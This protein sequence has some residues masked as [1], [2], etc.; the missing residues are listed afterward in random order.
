MP[1]S[2]LLPLGSRWARGGQ[3]SGP[4]P[5]VLR[6][7][8]EWHMM[9]PVPHLE[10]VWHPH[11]SHLLR[12]IDSL[13]ASGSCILL[14]MACPLA[15]TPSP[16]GSPY[17]S[18]HSKLMTL[19]SGDFPHPRQSEGKSLRTPSGIVP[20]RNILIEINSPAITGYNLPVQR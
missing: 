17:T 15:C 10:G 13:A 1:L 14:G 4:P 18:H 5:L 11:R 3:G 6:H 8:Q 12:G 2:Y 7:P 19:I 9:R 20:M 16:Q